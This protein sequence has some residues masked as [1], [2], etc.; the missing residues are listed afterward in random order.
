MLIPCSE[1][2]NQISDKALFCPHC[3][4]PMGEG[5]I[6]TPNKPKRRK[7]V[8]LPNGFGQISKLGNPN[9]RKPYRV[10]IPAG[11]DEKGRS[12]A[13]LL[14]P[15]AYFAT[16]N[17]AYAALTEYWNRPKNE[18]NIKVGELYE[19]W[20]ADRYRNYSE[21]VIHARYDFPWKYCTPVYD[22]NIRDVRASHIKYCMYENKISSERKGER[23]ASSVM[24]EKIKLIFNML[25]DY[26]VE[27]EYA[28]KNY[29][30]IMKG[31]LTPDEK[32][33]Q[34]HLSFS[35]EEL[36]RIR[37]SKGKNIYIDLL[38]IQCY[39]GW[40]PSEVLRL[41]T[42][43]VNLPKGSMTGGMKTE[44][45]KNREV[46]IHPYIADLIKGYYDEAVVCGRDLLFVTSSWKRAISY[47]TYQANFKNIKEE[48]NLDP[49]HS[50]HDGR[51]TFI[52]LAKNAGM[53]EFAIKKI[54][55]HSTNDLTERV[56][57]ERKFEWLASEMK[58]IVV[59]I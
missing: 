59:R 50:L 30:R 11:K 42:A 48:L 47:N 58:K 24:R 25:F 31:E 56:Y 53:D 10:M 23:A 2:N 5:K 33:N 17:E 3:G 26:A 6:A 22:M 18:K 15:N 7:R 4:L 21:K 44:N 43:D 38:L 29:A 40:R 37:K 45:G 20:K 39:S 51:K 12:K 27:N 14:K 55:G 36:D 1:C 28:D 32:K 35:E 49:A 52:T 19:M 57:T 9:Y 54:V 13:K 34:A 16:Y 8:R 41:T 46:P